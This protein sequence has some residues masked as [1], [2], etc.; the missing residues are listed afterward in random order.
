MKIILRTMSFVTKYWGQLL[1]SLICLLITT[2]ASLVVP[3]LLGRGVDSALNSGEKSLLIWAGVWIMVASL[4]RGLSAY[5]NRFLNQVVSQEV[6]YDIRNTLYNHIQ[7]LSFAYHDQAQTGQLMSRATADIEA[8]RM[9]AGEGVLTIFQTVLMIVGIS[10]ILIALN[11]Q[12]A[13]LTLIFMPAIGWRAIYV[14]NRLRPVNLLIQQ[15]VAALGTTVQESLSGMKVVKAF[16]RQK[17]E[18]LK[19]STDAKRLYDEH[20]KQARVQAF[21]QALMSML[22]GL[23]TVLILWNGGNQVINKTLTMGEVTQFVL[24]MGML[25]MP[26]RRLGMIANT[27]SRTMSAGQ[28]IFEILD[29][30]SPVKEKPGAKELGRISGQ[31]TFENVSFSYS[32]TPAPAIDNISF[33]AKPGQLVA[34][35]GGSGSGKSTLINLVSRFYDVTKGSITVDGVDIRDVTLASLRKNIGIA[36]QDVFLFSATIRDNIAYG[37]PDASLEQVIEAAKSAQINNFIQSMPDGYNSWV[38]ERGHTL[39]GGEKQRVAIARTLLVNPAIL[40]LDDSTSSVDAETEHLIRLA[41]ERLIQGRT[42]FIITHRLPLIKKAD[43]I[44]MLKD[45]RIEEK[46]THDEL[47]AKNGLYRQTY[48]SQLAAT[49]DAAVS[50]MEV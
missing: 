26:I 1:L 41:L 46:G 42:T 10:Y 27:I 15:L 29:T 12:L 11:W 3:R 14:S 32:G 22:L 9:F 47:M 24:Y 23:P 35:L 4:V 31:I 48:I 18:S 19:F 45:G 38:G 49:A 2:G 28:R 37:I 7:K 16:S 33:S 25:A 6:S 40:I 8:V 21:N 30:E 34:L 13:L 43:L 50:G 44:L 36:Q 39:S 5:G 17:E 20:I